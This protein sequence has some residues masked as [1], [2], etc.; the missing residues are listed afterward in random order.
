M[1]VMERVIKKPVLTEES[2][3]KVVDGRYTFEVDLKADKKSIAEEV[4][5]TFKVDVLGV[6]TRISKGKRLRIRGTFREKRG[7]KLKKA[8][9]TIASGQKISVFETGK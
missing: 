5:K 3:Q 2:L 4:A 6:R 7:S 9:V 8:T 1:I